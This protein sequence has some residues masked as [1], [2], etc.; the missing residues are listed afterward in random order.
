[1][2]RIMQY[3]V[4]EGSEASEAGDPCFGWYCK[5]QWFIHFAVEA[6]MV[7]VVKTAPK[8][9]QVVDGVCVKDG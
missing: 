7:G 1:M 6:V 5:R 4:R 3:G 9:Y 8:G 2:A